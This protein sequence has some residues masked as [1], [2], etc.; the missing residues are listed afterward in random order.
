MG[1]PAKSSAISTAFVHIFFLPSFST[2]SVCSAG[3]NNIPTRRNQRLP[4]FFP[5]PN[6]EI[7][8]PA[9]PRHDCCCPSELKTSRFLFRQQHEEDWR[10]S[11]GLRGVKLLPGWPFRPAL[12]AFFAFRALWASLGQPLQILCVGTTPSH[13]PSLLSCTYHADRG[14]FLAH[15]SL[16]QP[17]SSSA[18]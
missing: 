9:D 14:H 17:L 7:G 1:A 16:P 12:K 13:L 6:G 11:S 8:P 2:A 15:H 4:I 10:A 18:K 5:C 3:V